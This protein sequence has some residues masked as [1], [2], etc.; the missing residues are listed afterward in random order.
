MSPR[1][2]SAD[3]GAT[4]L[5]PGIC[6][7]H[8]AKHWLCCAPTPEAAPLGPRNTMEHWICPADMYSVLA[9]ELM[10]WSMACAAAGGGV[11]GSGKS[12]CQEPPPDQTVKE[13]VK[14]LY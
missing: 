11:S 14:M 9:A 1:A 2:S 13:V 10:M 12:Q 3:Q 7:Y 6:M 4:T 5:R 8:A